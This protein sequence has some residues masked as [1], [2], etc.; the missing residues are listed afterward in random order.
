M[1][2]VE[3]PACEGG[4]DRIQV[5]SFEIGNQNVRRSGSDFREAQLGGEGID[6]TCQDT[7]RK[8]KEG[9]HA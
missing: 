1:W 2:P 3:V 7:N 6:P 9:T 4:I 5:W 8:E